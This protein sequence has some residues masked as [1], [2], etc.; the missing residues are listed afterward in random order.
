MHLHSCHTSTRNDLLKS[1]EANWTV[2]T[3]HI[4]SMNNYATVWMH[5]INVESTM[6]QYW[7]LFVNS[8]HPWSDQQSIEMDHERAWMLYGSALVLCFTAV[9]QIHI[10]WASSSQRLEQAWWLEPS[11]AEETVA[12]QQ[13]QE[14]FCDT[15]ISIIWPGW[16]SFSHTVWTQ[17]PK[18]QE[19]VY[20]W[21]NVWEIERRTLQG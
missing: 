11:G 4:L 21:L 17:V 1:Q 7:R 9:C 13:C 15:V 16:V 14:L 5:L 12:V 19:S 20:A 2:Y 18:R 3:H 6:W 8:L 10:S